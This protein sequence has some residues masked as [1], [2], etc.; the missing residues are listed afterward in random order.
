MA[1]EIKRS[2]EQEGNGTGCKRKRKC[3][4]SSWSGVGF[5]YL[6]NQAT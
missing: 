4:E 3:K 2:A 1:E 5:I 6:I